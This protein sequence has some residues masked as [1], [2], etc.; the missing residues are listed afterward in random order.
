MELLYRLKWPIGNIWAR[1]SSGNGIVSSFDS[2][3]VFEG[4]GKKRSDYN[5]ENPLFTGEEIH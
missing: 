1:S 2:F 3:T 5:S 4:S